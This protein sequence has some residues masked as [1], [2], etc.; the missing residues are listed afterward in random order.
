MSFLGPA[1]SGPSLN[2]VLEYVQPPLLTGTSDFNSCLHSTN[3]HLPSS[4]VLLQ[5]SPP[6][7]MSDLFLDL[8]DGS[9]LLDLLEVMSGQSLVSLFLC[10]LIMCSK[11][12]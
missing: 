6:S 12:M 4:C 3:G 10:E 9:K 2:L 7:R 11:S 8:R 1:S 5:R